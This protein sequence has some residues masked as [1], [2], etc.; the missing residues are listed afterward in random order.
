MLPWPG[1]NLIPDRNYFVLPKGPDAIWDDTIGGPI[2]SPDD[3]TGTSR[4]Q[5]DWLIQSKKRRAVGPD[6]DLGCAFAGTVGVM[7]AHGVLFPISVKPFAIP[8]AFIGS[9]RHN[10]TGIPRK[11][12]GI[13]DVDGAHNISG[14]GF[15]RD[16]V[17]ESHQRL[18]GEVE[19]NLRL[20]IL[21]EFYEGVPVTKITAMVGKEPVGESEL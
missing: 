15:G 6:D 5:F 20:E 16:L 21:Q 13:K 9:H 4:S 1:G 2:T 19:N 18:G 12:H 17:R 3:I 7:A 14:K 11:A 10:P 8:I